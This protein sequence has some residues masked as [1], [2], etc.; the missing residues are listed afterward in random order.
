MALDVAGRGLRSSRVGR[1]IAR[2]RGGDAHG[3][4]GNRTCHS[5]APQI[6]SRTVTASRRPVL[7]RHEAVHSDCT[8]PTRGRQEGL[9]LLQRGLRRAKGLA[10]RHRSHRPPRFTRCEGH[11]SSKEHCQGRRPQEVTAST[12]RLGRGPAN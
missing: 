12:A 6:K 10:I 9:S 2:A 3:H 11:R 7:L 1:G 5:A 4:A 8:T